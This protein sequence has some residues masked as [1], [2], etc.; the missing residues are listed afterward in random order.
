MVRD[1]LFLHSTLVVHTGIVYCDP[2]TGTR[3]TV[4]SGVFS[5]GNSTRNSIVRFPLVIKQIETLVTVIH[6]IT[7]YAYHQIFL[8]EHCA[9]GVEDKNYV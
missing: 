4:L 6:L 7:S 1:V 3:V 2:S 9:C 8:V 5:D